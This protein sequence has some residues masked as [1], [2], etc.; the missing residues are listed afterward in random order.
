MSTSA[1]AK[2]REACSTVNPSVVVSTTSPVEIWPRRHNSTDQTNT[3][4]VTKNTVTAWN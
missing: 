3:P 2:S 1:I 4:A